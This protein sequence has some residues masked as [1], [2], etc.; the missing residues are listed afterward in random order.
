MFRMENKSVML[1][2]GQSGS[3]KSDFMKKLE[4]YYFEIW[5]DNKTVPINWE[6]FFIIGMRDLYHEEL[7]ARRLRQ[8]S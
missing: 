2:G 5:R 4:S 7:Y 3:G 6:D 1:I 8:K